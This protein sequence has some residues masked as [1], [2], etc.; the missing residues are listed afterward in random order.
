MI[1]E[2]VVALLKEKDY[3]IATAESCTGGLVAGRIVNVAGASGVFHEGYI[4]YSNEAKC[5]L[6]GVPAPLLAQY[7]AVSEQTA[8][9]MAIG[10]AHAANA[11]VGVATTGI[12]GPDGGTEEKP[13]GTVFI[14][15]CVNNQAIVR[16][17]H[18][19]GN[20]EQVRNNAVES[21]LQLV[22]ECL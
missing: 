12:A 6:L 21:A 9:E 3:T 16:E 4:T 17:C 20:R 7:G 11:E 8:K 19:N 15:C 5:R 14:G 10:V 22:W 1:E 18:F 13:V 2:K